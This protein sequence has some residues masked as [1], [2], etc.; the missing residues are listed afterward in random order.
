MG[1]LVRSY[2]PAGV[3]FD[4]HRRDHAGPHVRSAIQSIEL[5][6]HYIGTGR[7]IPHEDALRPPPTQSCRSPLVPV[8]VAIRENETN[9]VVSVA[10]LVDCPLLR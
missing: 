5:L 7:V 1:P 10:R 2:S 6:A 9:D 3:R 8:I 4:R